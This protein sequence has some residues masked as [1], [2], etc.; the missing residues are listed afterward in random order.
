MSFTL[1]SLL[2]INILALLSGLDANK[3]TPTGV[4]AIYLATDTN[5]LYVS[6]DGVNWSNSYVFN[7]LTLTSLSVGNTTINGTLAGTMNVIGIFN[8]Y[9]NINLRDSHIQ[10]ILS[11][12]TLG[13][14]ATTFLCNSEVMIITGDIGGNTLET[15]TGGTTGGELT[16]IFVDAYVTLTDNESHTV[17]TFELSAAF[18][19]AADKVLK[20]LFDGASWYEV[21]RSAD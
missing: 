9:N 6:Y 19:S 7:A 1:P 16:L 11:P 20:L 12:L 13:V 4:G 17:N 3:G 5:K 8:M 14:G 10:R 15:I 18:T 2:N 21:G